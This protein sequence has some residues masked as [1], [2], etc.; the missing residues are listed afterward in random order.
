MNSKRTNRRKRLAGM[1]LALA[2]VAAVA[3]PAGT[4]AMPHPR[5]H[6]PVCGG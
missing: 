6:G 3:A 1:L 2:L 4:P 5:C